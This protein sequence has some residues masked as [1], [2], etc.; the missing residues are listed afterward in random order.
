MNYCK[1]HLTATII[2]LILSSSP[3]TK[4]LGYKL[5]C[6]KLTPTLQLTCVTMERDRKLAPYLNLVIQITSQLM[7]Q[8]NSL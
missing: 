4:A 6:N 3:R 5:V 7:R 2:A 8:F 1:Q